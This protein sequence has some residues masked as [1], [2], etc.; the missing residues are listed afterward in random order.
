MSTSWN[1]TDTSTTS[2]GQ[3][4]PA[5]IN[6][7]ADFAKKTADASS[8]VIANLTSPLDRIETIRYAAQR[9]SNIY[10]GANIEPGYYSP[11]KSGMSILIQDNT[12]L[13]DEV[14]G[15]RV[16]YPFSAHIVMRVPLSAVVTESV[17][18]AVI[19]RLIGACYE[20]SGTTPAPRLN[21]LIRGAVLP[22]VMV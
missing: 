5:T 8:V 1:F 19:N 6:Y 2:V 17:L 4:Q 3:I 20:Q 9:V 12:V 14:D 7:S 18:N 15:V 10:S 13:T 21:K 16:D 11:V 22:T